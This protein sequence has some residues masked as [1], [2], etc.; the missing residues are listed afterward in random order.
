MAKAFS[1]SEKALIQK[2]L[3]EQGEKHFSAYGLKKTSVEEIAKAAGISKGAFYS[4]YGSKEELF[5]D[6]MEQTEL[7]FRIKLLDV[8]EQPGENPRSKLTEIFR[9]A[10]SMIKEIP[11]LRFVNQTDYELIFQR[12]PMEKFR[13]HMASDQTFAEEMI[14]RC[15]A[16]GIQICVPPEKLTG[17]LYPLVMSVFREEGPGQSLFNQHIDSHLELL[18]AYALGEVVLKNDPEIFGEGKH[19]ELGD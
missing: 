16:K 5:M 4:F 7:K 19:H 2:R 1:I 10:F 13:E 9:Y 11:I 8:I 12:V 15:R 6:V 3:L 17:M 18:A 14:K